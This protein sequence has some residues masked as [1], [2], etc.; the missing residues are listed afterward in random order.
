MSYPPGKHRGR[1]C[2]VCQHPEAGR[3][4]Y[5]IVTGAGERGK[6]RRGLAEKFGLTPDAIYNHSRHHI[7]PEYRRAI[8]AGPFR[9]EDDRLGG[10]EGQASSGAGSE[11]RG[12]RLG[13][14]E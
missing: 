3:I 14:V 12:L 5:L 11:T 7:S 2:T 8:L 4:D 6:G 13:A 10:K 9:S 1:K